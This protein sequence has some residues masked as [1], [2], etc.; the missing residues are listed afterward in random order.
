MKSPLLALALV[1]GCGTE[2]ATDSLT[3]AVG[4]CGPSET[5]VVGVFEP[6]PSGDGTILLRVDRPGDHSIVVSSHEAATWKIVA[7]N[8]ARVTHVYAVGMGKQRVIAPAGADVSTESDAEG[9]AFACGYTWPGNGTCDTKGLLRLASIRLNKH[10][11][12][13]HGCYAATTFT[14]GEDMAVTSDCVGLE[15]SGAA[16]ADLIARCDAEQ[17]ESDCGGVVLY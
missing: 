7:S 12:S 4:E 17:D 1:V 15:R 10:A 5:H 6:V 16:Q 13:F 2:E 11:T 3:R 14:I 9:G 8:G